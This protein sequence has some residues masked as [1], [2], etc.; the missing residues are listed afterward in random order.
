MN[1]ARFV[2]VLVLA[3]PIL[4]TAGEFNPT[5][6]IGAKAPVWAELPGV[7]G[8]P[9]SMDDFKS[10]DVL[11]LVFTC[12]SCPYAVDY[13][14]RI[15]EL[16]NLSQ[17]KDA[18]F[19]V[20]AINVNLVKEDLLPAMKERATAKKFNFHYLFDESQQT[21]KDYGAT[22][23]P[24]FFVLNRER[25]VVYMGAFD[26]NTDAK[27]VTRRHVQEAIA[28]TIAGDKIEISETVAIGCGVRYQRKRRRPKPQPVD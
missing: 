27:K 8:K 23:T 2:A 12:N 5:L 18:K 16:A 9:Y 14:D 1:F 7:D 13:E 22:F 3:T 24:E 6:D 4:A 19:K 25:Q 11:V 15:I 20:V 17:E 28:A 21:A 26:D 10:A